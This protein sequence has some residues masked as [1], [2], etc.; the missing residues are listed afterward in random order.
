MNFKNCL[1]FDVE[2]LP[3]YFLLM[4]K[5]VTTGEV[6]FFEKFNDSELNRKN[7]LYIL[8]KYKLISFNG[9]KYDMLIIEA[10][11]AGFSNAAIKKVSDMII[12]DN[13]QP[14]QVRKH[15]GFAA[16]DVDHIDLIE[17]APLKA[18]LKLYSGRLHAKTMQDLP[19]DPSENI[20]DRTRQKLIPYCENDNDDNILL[21]KRLE[22]EID[23][24]VIMG[25]EIAIDLRSKSDAQIA[26]AV[27]K[28][29]CQTRYGFTPKN[30]RLI[31][32]LL[33]N[34]KRLKI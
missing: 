14:W 32:T 33:I 20:T 10:A 15:F 7:I 29:Q 27:I 13:Q 17:V 31:Q 28:Y 8:N 19:V 25:D 2:C 4:F 11:I 22:K 1:S 9:I 16:L 21:A 12:N 23:L 30:Q 5:K 24:R 18:S 26:E 3:N 34:I 6:M